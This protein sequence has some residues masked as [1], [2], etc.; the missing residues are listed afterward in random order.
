MT[1]AID[2]LRRRSAATTKVLEALNDLP[3]DDRA[4]VLAEI[5]SAVTKSQD[6]RKEHNASMVE[7]AP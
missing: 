6:Q 3:L 4:W 5:Y 1:L 2:V 7:A